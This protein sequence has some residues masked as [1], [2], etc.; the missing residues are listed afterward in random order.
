MEMQKRAWKEDGKNQWE[1]MLRVSS[2]S[3]R[4]ERER[5]NGKSEKNDCVTEKLNEKQ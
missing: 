2:V 4:L 1:N 5:V 3:G